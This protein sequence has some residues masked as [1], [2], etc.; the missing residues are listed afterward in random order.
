M[1][2]TIARMMRRVHL[3]DED[4]EIAEDACRGL[5]N[6]YRRDAERHSNPVIRDPMLERAVRLEG[7]A[8]RMKRFREGSAS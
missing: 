8:D 6:R 5:A 2:D 1:L 7:M 3:T 4:L